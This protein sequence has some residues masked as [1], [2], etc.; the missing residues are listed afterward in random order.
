MIQAVVKLFLNSGRDYITI[1]SLVDYKKY[2]QLA[3]SSAQ[4][5]R[6][7]IISLVP[8]LSKTSQ[9]RETLTMYIN[10]S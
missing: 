10:N 7:P 1:S 3:A 8:Y 5:I 9:L 2:N 6:L 4:K